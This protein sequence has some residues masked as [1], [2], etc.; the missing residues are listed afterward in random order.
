MRNKKAEWLYHYYE[1]LSPLKLQA[2]DFTGEFYKIF[3]EQI[4]SVLYKFFQRIKKEG[5]APVLAIVF[6][7]VIPPSPTLTSKDG[8]WH[9]GDFFFLLQYAFFGWG[10]LAMS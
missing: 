4:I 8:E 7:S 1:P 10:R 3:K 6:S 2:Y 5:L 9:M